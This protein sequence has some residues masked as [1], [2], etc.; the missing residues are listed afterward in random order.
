LDP[1]KFIVERGGEAEYHYLINQ[2]CTVEGNASPLKH[3]KGGCLGR[4]GEGG[5]GQRKGNE[6]L[7]TGAFQET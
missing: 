5:M 1:F 4:T 2:K 6:A 7:A 3:Q